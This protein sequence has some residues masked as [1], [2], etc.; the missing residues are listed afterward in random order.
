MVDETHEDE[1]L[2]DI[3]IGDDGVRKEILK[4][5]KYTK[6]RYGDWIEEAKE[7][8]RFALGDQ[9]NEED[10]NALKEQG[11]PALTF[12]RIRPLV[13][14]VSG[15]QRDNS[16]R[17][18]V[19][20]EG[21]EDQ[22]FSQVM[23]RLLKAVDKWSQLTFTLG[24]YFD[25]GCYC[26]KSFLEAVIDYDKDPIRGE[27]KFKLRSPYKIL[28]DPDFLGYDLNDG[29]RYLFKITKLTK[30]ELKDLY[31][32]KKDLINAFAKDCD[33]VTESLDG[34]IILASGH[35]DDYTNR[36]NITTQTQVA[37]EEDNDEEDLALGD[38]KF[39]VKEYWNPKKVEKYF[40][41]D[42]DD[43]EPVRFDTEE[44]ADGFV[45]KQ[46]VGKVVKRKVNEMHVEA[47][48]CGVILQ[49]DLSPFEPY[50]SGYPFFR[51]LADWAP[52]A[53]Q[54]KLRVQGIVRPLK[55]PQREKNKAK[56]QN[57]HI[58]STQANSGWV[59]EE[60]ALDPEGWLKLEKMGSKP[61][62]VV[63]LKKGF[64]EKLKEIIP[65]G[66]NIG[67][68]QREDKAEEEFKQISSINPDLM[69]IQDKT[70]S[71]RAISLRIKQAVLALARLFFNYRYSKEIIG[72]F[73]FDMV[74]ML[75][76]IS[77]MEKTIGVAYMKKAVDEEK[78][79]EG[80][81]EGHLQAFLTMIKDKKYDVS[82][83]EANNNSTLRFEIFQELTELLKAGA[84]IPIKLLVE[85]LDLPNSQEV[86][87]A[88]EEEQ[89]RQLAIAAAGN[90]KKK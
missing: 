66:P 40:V 87:K 27:I 71:G 76:D 80:L 30:R 36:P 73:I 12:N 38:V 32:D 88:V 86:L 89:Q 5:Y 61:G 53:G 55:D 48:S 28:P 11:R 29:C 56:S 39:T 83:T 23:D 50:Y 16:S 13:N 8:Y 37:D 68:L 57:L 2:K 21:G 35:N 52:N 20:P 72:N 44:K 14:I 58:L 78:Y 10:L 43:G 79:P 84:P 63:K 9:W 90:K 74:P 70:A 33:D 54:E 24:Y 17:I 41:I 19:N 49:D 77:K 3:E 65:K 6:K 15:Y 18:K 7:D 46:G 81:T 51:F 47:L 4:R 59:G 82:I 60:E 45:T 64:M 75:F 69:G 25:D 85:Y 67:Q 26:G 22:I 31:P 1:E 34:K 62:L 42:K